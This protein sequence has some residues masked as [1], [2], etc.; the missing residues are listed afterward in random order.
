MLSHFSD[1][2]VHVLSDIHPALGRLYLH[3]CFC[4]QPE[5]SMFM[6]AVLL[7]DVC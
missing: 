6:V 1:A 3:R 2:C 7:G 5:V 4:F